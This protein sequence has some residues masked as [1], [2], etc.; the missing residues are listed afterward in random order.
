MQDDLRSHPESDAAPDQQDLV[1][2]LVPVFDEEES[3]ERFHA[4]LSEVLSNWGR[5]YEI[6]I[7]DDGS[8]DNTPKLLDAISQSDDKVT[9]V[10]LRTNFG[11]T[12]ALTAAM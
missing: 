10:S 7:V 9:V 12:A 5:D 6:V 2:V 4:E 3:I 1:S 8:R 11:Q